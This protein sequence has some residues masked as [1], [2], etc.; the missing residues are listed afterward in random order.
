M[1]NHKSARK[2]VRQSEKRRV[3]RKGYLSGVKTVVKSYQ[4]AL[5]ELSQGKG[6]AEQVKKLFSQAQSALQKAAAKGILH[7]NNASRRV[8]RLL[9]K[10]RSVKN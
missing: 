3:E 5:H 8:G 1:A 6:D 10:M 9:H 7:K 4:S 2:R